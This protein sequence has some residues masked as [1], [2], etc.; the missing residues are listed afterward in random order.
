MTTKAGFAALAVGVLVGA[1]A[2]GCR[3]D[4]GDLGRLRP[5][6]VENPHGTNCGLLSP[7]VQVSGTATC[8]GRLASSLLSNALCSCGDLK[9]SNALI[10]H[11]FD[12]RQGPYE[13]NQPEEGGASIGVNGNFTQ[14]TGSGDIGG[15]LSLAGG[16]DFMLTGSL[17][18]KGDFWTAGNVTTLG[19]TNVG[20][21]AWLGGSYTGAGPLT[22]RGALHHAGVAFALLVTAASNETGA[23]NVRKPCP[24]GADE[25]LDIGAIVDAGRLDNDNE[26]RG[27]VPG[28]LAALAGTSVALTLPCGRAYFTGLGGE[29]NVTFHVSGMSAVFIDG[30]LH[31]TGSLI[32]DIAAGAEVDVFV[33]GD[34]K[35]IGKLVLASKER[36]GAG[37]L[38]VGGSQPIGPLQ[39][40]WVGALYAP[41]ASVFAQVGLEAWGS[42]FAADF[43]SDSF[44]TFF[45]DRSVADAGATC[46]APAPSAC[47]QCG[48]CAGGNACVGGVCGSCSSDADCCSLGTC[49]NG[50]CAPLL[51]VRGE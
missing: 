28:Q 8:S 40:P 19:A 3:V 43:A 6:R 49:A 33:K 5:G 23:V 39:S 20:R 7:R 29:G 26:A 34:A 31:L 2:S 16:A 48:T 47:R 37:R 42:I 50:Q 35:V 25:V 27:F 45:Y 13:M 22:V 4:D 41:H 32:F 17:I 10:T 44:A 38:W 14:L 1:G 30:D 9:V 18:V 36:P 51:S 11:G 21:N 46:E 24:C 15:S 12:S